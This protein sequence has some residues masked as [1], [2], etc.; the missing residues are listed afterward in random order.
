M[1]H[2]PICAVNI[3]T[4]IKE[5]QIMLKHDPE[6]DLLK[7]HNFSLKP[8]ADVLGNSSHQETIIKTEPD[9]DVPGNCSHQRI[10]KTDPDADVPGNSSHQTIIKTEPDADVPGNSSHQETIIKTEPDDGDDREEEKCGIKKE[11]VNTGKKFLKPTMLIVAGRK[12]R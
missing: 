1:K 4:E 9:A 3:K 10:I 12:N 6:C 5:E 8:D 11:I 2:E 7:M